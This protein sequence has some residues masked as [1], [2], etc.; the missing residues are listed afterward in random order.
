MAKTYITSNRTPTK[1]LFN[2]RMSYN[3]TMAQ[4]TY[5]NLV[6]FN[7]G[8]KYLYGRVNRLFVPMMVN[9][10][11]APIKKFNQAIVQAKG[12]GALAFVVDA[13]NDLAQQF[14]KCA[15]TRKIDTT[16]SYLT[17]LKVYKAYESPERVYR[18]YKN[19]YFA[20]M[21]ISFKKQ[22]IK[23][24]NF[25]EFLDHLLLLLEATARTE[26]LTRPGYIKS[27][28]AP[29]GCSGLVIE[30]ADLDTSNDQAKIDRF[31]NSNNWNFYLNA[32]ASY[33]FMVDRRIPWRLVADIG[34]LPHKSRMLD[35]AAAY[36]LNSTNKIIDTYYKSAHLDYFKNFKSDLFTLYNKVKLKNFLV[37]EQYKG[38]TISR[39]I[40][41]ATYTPESLAKRYPDENFLRLYFKIRFLEE[42]SQFTTEQQSLMIDDCIE[43]YLAGGL[44]SSLGSFERILNKTFDYSGSL[45][46]IVEHLKAVEGAEFAESEGTT[47]TT[48]ATM[49]ASSGY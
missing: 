39:R 38:R 18:A 17:N 20:A 27:R 40:R 23:V 31:V 11:R 35:Y 15:M 5:T 26:P 32:C 8:E 16:D 36:G 3:V 7:F 46:Y 21:A 24:R 1:D 45:S 14:Q 47:A 29:V 34:A 28:R 12:L 9:E 43:L 6:D 41:P 10:S 33:G 37:T 42:E 49:G 2:Q 19:I 22:K 25:G 4:S 44:D 48:S 30:I 13:F